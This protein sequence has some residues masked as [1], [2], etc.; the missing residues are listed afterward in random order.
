MLVDRTV[1]STPSV[2]F[3]IDPLHSLISADQLLPCL[4]TL[5]DLPSKTTCHYFLKGSSDIYKLTSS[6]GT[7]YVRLYHHNYRRFESIEFELE[8][9]TRL[10][11]MGVR[12]AIPLK[13]VNGSQ[14]STISA[15]EGKRHLAV[16]TEAQG[17]SNSTPQPS[18]LKLA[19]ATLAHL[20]KSAQRLPL[21]TTLPSYD[22]DH[23][24]STASE[25]IHQHCHSRPELKKV[26][27]F[28]KYLASQLKQTLQQFPLEKLNWG[29]IHGDLIH[30]NFHFNKNEEITF[31]DFDRIGYGWHVF[32]I[33]S[34]LGQL[35]S[36]RSVPEKSKL[37]NEVS[38]YFLKGYNSIS[39]VPQEQLDLLPLFRKRY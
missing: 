8:C 13:N 4:Q 12:S 31:F 36:H 11:E 6:I 1:H 29:V 39:P 5:Y 9:V 28:Y 34:Y 2:D 38:L 30:N 26:G 22:L 37:F 24:L 19:G 10:N 27:I 33:A 21:S 7:F 32:E 23:C 25:K 17:S 16:F 20:H 35:A 14:L 15:P 18:Q 3:K